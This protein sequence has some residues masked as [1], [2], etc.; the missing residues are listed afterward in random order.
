MR[1]GL[2]VQAGFGQPEAL[3]RPV[4]NEVFGN[5][6]VY[7]FEVDKTIPDS[8]GVDH[9]DRAMLALVEAAGLVSANNMLEASI[10]DG[11]LKS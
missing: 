9:D 8:L 2:R 7:I 5:D 4:V 6:L 1:A 3:H 11:I 10:F